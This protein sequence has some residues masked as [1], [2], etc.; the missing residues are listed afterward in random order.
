MSTYT[1]KAIETATSVAQSAYN[2]VDPYVPQ[3]AKTAAGYAASTATSTANFA[4]GTATAAVNTT[5]NTIGAAVGF[6]TSTATA[7]K[8]RAVATAS[9]ALK[10]TS[11]TA[12]WVF[13][14]ATTTVTAYTP[15]PVVN[16]VSSAVA[17]AQALRQDPVGT[18]K[19]YVPTFVIHT[20]EKTYEIVHGTY[21]KGTATVNA[22][23]GYIVTKVNGT[24]QYVTN[25]P[26][27]HSLLEQLNKLAAPVLDRV[28]G[29]KKSDD[30]KAEEPAVEAK[31]Q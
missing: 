29:G 14:S 18:V 8:D 20:G 27:V 16:A 9:G 24:V 26:Q 22:T 6:T 11:D 12:T 1:E 30:D 10:Y 7:V 23:T 2:R 31:E 4:I 17:G 21:E 5:T 25:I 13:T 3:V 15:S 19:P 28:R